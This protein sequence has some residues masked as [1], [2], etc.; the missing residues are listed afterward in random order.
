M[1]IDLPKTSMRL[2]DFLNFSKRCIFIGIGGQDFF[3]K[4]KRKEGRGVS[5]PAF[6]KEYFPAPQD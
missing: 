2:S 1:L 3:R 5:G 6:L 4:H